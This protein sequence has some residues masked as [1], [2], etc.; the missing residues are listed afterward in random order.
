MASILLPTREV[1]ESVRSVVRQL[2]SEDELLLLCDTQDDPVM[3]E[4]AS[5]S[6]KGEIDVVP[7]GDPERCSG[8]AHALAVGLERASQDRIV[9]TDDDVERDGNWLSQILGLVERHG[10]VAAT[11]LFVSEGFWW[12]LFEPMMVTF[13]TALLCRYGGVWGGG[14]AF[15]RE[16]L[17]EARYRRDLERTVSDD[18]LL[19]DCLDDVYTSPD[20]VDTVYVPSD[21]RSV[22][23]RLTRFI[24]SYHHWLPRGTRGLFIASLCYLGLVLL[25]PFAAAIGVTLGSKRVYDA[26]DVERRTWLLAFPCFLLLPIVIATTWLHPEFNWGGRHYRWSG[27]FDV[28]IE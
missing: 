7:V 2:R 11:P 16:E 12:R 17:D 21:P 24:L 15:D 1:T 22:R 14:V 27:R 4:S 23:D 25:A 3:D 8:K 28:R 6:S 26:Y 19:W 18:A 10:A 13:G 5:L 9:L 20:L